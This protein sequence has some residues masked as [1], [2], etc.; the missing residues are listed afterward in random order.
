MSSSEGGSSVLF[1]GTRCIGC[2]GCS[3]ACKS[4]NRKPDDLDLEKVS[5]EGGIEGKANLSAKT[6]TF[7]RY[8]EIGEGDDLKWAF[9]KIQCMHCLNPACEAACI[10]GALRRE[11]GTG[12]VVYH[13]EKCIGCRYCMVACPF[14]IPTYEWDKVSPWIKKC[15]FCADRQH[16][17]DAEG[18]REPACE[19]ACPTG[20]LKFFE[21]RD[22]AI[23]EAEAR[24]AADPDRYYKDEDGNLHIYGQHEAGGT[25]W[26][27]IFPSSVSPD[28]MDMPQVSNESVPRN[29]R[30]AMGTL[31]YYAIGVI[32]L[33]AAIYWVTKRRQKATAG[34]GEKKEG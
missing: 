2:R 34:A 28:D 23:A 1:D 6:F 3:V 24:F 13:R 17:N 16:G 31:P 12:A 25:G 29:S 21:K 22:D 8:R 19:S 32:G 18:S 14:G 7:M 11:G 20:A 10:V 33:M 5:V 4:W 9:V 30:K 15:T 27:Y 26:M